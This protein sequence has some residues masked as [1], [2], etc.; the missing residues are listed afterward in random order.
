VEYQIDRQ[1]AE[2]RNCRCRWRYA[3]GFGVQ[4]LSFIGFSLYPY[5]HSLDTKPNFRRVT[6]VS[7]GIRFGLDGD[8]KLGSVKLT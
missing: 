3:I 8:T 2:W 5:K 6:N 1:I 4:F 7:Y